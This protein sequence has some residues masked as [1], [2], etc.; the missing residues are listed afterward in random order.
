MTIVD[1][2]ICRSKCRIVQSITATPDISIRQSGLYR[3][4]TSTNVSNLP[5][6]QLLQHAGWSATGILHGLDEGDPE[7][8]SLSP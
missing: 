3:L 8:F 1:A 5:M 6:Q 4:F 7:L 2:I